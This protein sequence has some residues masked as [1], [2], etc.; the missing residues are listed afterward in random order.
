MKFIIIQVGFL[1]DRRRINVAVTRARRQCCL[2]CDTETVS[3]DKF[4]KRLIEYFEENGEYLS[5]SE[6]GNEWDICIFKV[7]GAENEQFSCSAKPVFYPMF[8]SKLTISEYFCKTTNKDSWLHSQSH[9]LHDY[10]KCRTFYLFIIFSLLNIWKMVILR[11]EIGLEV[12]IADLYGDEVVSMLTV[13]YRM[14]E[15]IWNWSS[16]EL[17]NSKVFYPFSYI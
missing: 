13:Q 9:F 15:L 1:S 10:I 14:H 17:Y 7:F 6:Y 8:M 2:I 3:N 16:K 12:D 4:L 5:G 11:V